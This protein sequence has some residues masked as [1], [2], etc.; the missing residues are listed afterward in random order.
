[1]M[2]TIKS[3]ITR[4]VITTFLFFLFVPNGQAQRRAKK[5]ADKDTENWRYEIECTGTG[6]DG[7][8]LIKVWSYSK[9]PN[10]AI[11]QSKK[12][13]IHGII[14]KG[15]PTGDRGCFAQPPLAQSSNLEEEKQ[16]YFYDFFAEGGKYQKF[17][18]LSTDGAINAEDRFK[19]GKGQYKIGIIVSVNKDLLRKE[20]EDAGILKKLSSGF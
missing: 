8:Y 5:I 12:N 20:L 10:V 6:R 11:E 14:F 1:M 17:V 16:N 18:T 15:V 4:I 2:P 3:T 19:L 13:A 7:T 9:K